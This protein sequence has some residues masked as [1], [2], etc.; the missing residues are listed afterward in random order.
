MFKDVLDSIAIGNDVAVEFPFA[1]QNLAEQL[2]ARAVGFS[3]HPRVR[4]HHRRCL[5]FAEARFEGR[6]VGFAQV[7][8]I[9]HGI[10][11]VAL[12]LRSAVHGEVLGRR[13]HLQIARIGDLQTFDVG[14]S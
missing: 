2:M 4:R 7:A 10:E 3:I 9:H 5:A 6:Q 13:H 1:P 11:L 12:R 8:L 14:D